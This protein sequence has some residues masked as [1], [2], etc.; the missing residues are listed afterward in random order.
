MWQL[1]G[2][3]TCH[4][5]ARISGQGVPGLGLNSEV[6]ARSGILRLVDS[7]FGFVVLGSSSLGA[8]AH[9]GLHFGVGLSTRACDAD[10]EG[11]RTKNV[12]PLMRPSIHAYIC[13]WKHMHVP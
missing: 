5:L 4:G 7:A 8:G 12:S 10:V 3:S 1:D 6:T 9:A 13:M 2:G 11:L